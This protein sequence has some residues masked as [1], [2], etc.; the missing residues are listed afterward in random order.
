MLDQRHRVQCWNPRISLIFSH[1]REKPPNKPALFVSMSSIF[2]LFSL[3]SRRAFTIGQHPPKHVNTEL[4]PFILC[5][6]AAI[7]FY[8]KGAHPF[9]H[10]TFFDRV[11]GTWRGSIRTISRRKYKTF[12]S[13]QFYERK[14]FRNIFLLDSSWERVFC[15]LSRLQLIRISRQVNRTIGNCSLFKP[16]CFIFNTSIIRQEDNLISSKVER[17]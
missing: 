15:F 9:L 14:A 17:T 10:L 7:S 4:D 12:Y 16:N 1:Q 11:G 2:D 13:V 6:L 8:T 3:T 5:T